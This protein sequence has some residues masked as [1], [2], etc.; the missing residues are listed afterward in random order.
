[1]AGN[2]NARTIVCPTCLYQQGNIE[3]AQRIRE[4]IET[5]WYRCQHDHENGICWDGEPLPD[6]P[7]WPATDKQEKAARFVRAALDTGIDHTT[8]LA[9]LAELELI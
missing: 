2:D 7:L 5:D 1:M 4:G 9:K 3:P 8:I 6:S